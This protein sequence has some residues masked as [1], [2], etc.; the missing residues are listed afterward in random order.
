[1]ITDIYETTG[2]VFDDLRNYRYALWRIWDK[3]KPVC[4]FIMLN[5]S[6]ADDIKNDPTVTRCINYAKSWGFGTLY[7]RNIFALRSTDPKALLKHPDPVGQFNDAYIVEAAQYAKVTVVAWG[8]HGR[9]MKRGEIVLDKLHRCGF[10][11]YCLGLTK[12]GQPR[13]P[14]YLPNTLKP[15]PWRV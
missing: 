8:T 1:M 5:P 4:T 10:P 7:V 6:T 11:V 9:I 3:S 15:I 13:H 12:C 2:A 14:L